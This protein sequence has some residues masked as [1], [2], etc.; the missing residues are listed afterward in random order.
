MKREA[1]AAVPL[2]ELAV[3]GRFFR[4]LAGE[5]ALDLCDD[6]ACLTVPPGFDLVV[7]TDTIASGVHFLPDDPPTATS[8]VKGAIPSVTEG[9]WG[10]PSGRPIV[11]TWNKQPDYWLPMA[12]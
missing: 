6:A 10:T 4:P 2:D 8:W 7:T 9:S 11:T 5:G 12:A 3:I 1:R